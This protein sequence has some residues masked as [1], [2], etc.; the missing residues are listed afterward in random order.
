MG[1]SCSRPELQEYIVIGRNQ[2]STEIEAHESEVQSNATTS[3]ALTDEATE[4][5]VHVD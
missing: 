1:K 3:G 2:V 4:I 5:S